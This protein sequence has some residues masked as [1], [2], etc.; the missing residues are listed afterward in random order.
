LLEQIWNGILGFTQQLVIPDWGGLVALIPIG[1][2]AFVGLWLVL[3]VRRFALA[4]PTRRGK[5]RV[6][7]MPP[8]GVHLGPVSFAPIL[9]ATGLFLVLLGLVFGGALIVAG[10]AAFVLTL[11]YWGRE[12]LADYDHLVHAETAPPAVVHPGPPPG[13]HMI[14]P[15][16]RPIVA[17]LGLAVLF[18]G[19]VFGGWL[20]AVG[21]I[22][23]ILSLIGW[24]ADARAEYVKAVEADR[25]G[26][27]EALPAP[28][29]PKGILWMFAVLVIAAVVLNAGI[30]P[31]KSSTAAGAGGSGQPPASGGPAGSGAPGGS[32][33]PGGIA[34]SAEGLKF[35]TDALKTPADKPFKISFDNK[36]AGITHDIAIQDSGGTILF[37]GADV[38]G[39]KTETYD[40]PA[41][42]PGS[43]KFVCT[44]HANMTGTLT[45]G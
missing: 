3:T 35:S 21:V 32:G 27:L 2:V 5:R 45:A 34:I 14:G 16:F 44:F 8:P 13:V 42:K 38:P 36:D 12:G 11:L 4:G 30:L 25:T 18:Y 1:L 7:P 43:Y 20:L 6:Q 17:S 26:H 22:L 33:G 19:L 29:W 23:L 9:G 28:S 24:L 31:P 39:P 10:I 40:V 41:L 37:N 15:S